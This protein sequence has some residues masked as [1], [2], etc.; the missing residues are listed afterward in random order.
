MNGTISSLRFP[1]TGHMITWLGRPLLE[2][3]RILIYNS[4]SFCGQNQNQRFAME[5]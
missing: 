2:P 5:V 1:A 4:D 3:C